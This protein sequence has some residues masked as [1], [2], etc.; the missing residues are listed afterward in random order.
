MLAAL[1]HC[2]RA[3]LW[4]C[5]PSPLCCRPL[6]SAYHHRHKQQ[7]KVVAQ[8]VSDSPHTDSGPCSRHSMTQWGTQQLRCCMQGASGGRPHACTLSHQAI[9]Q[10]H[11]SAKEFD[12][13]CS[14]AVTCSGGSASSASMLVSPPKP[15]SGSTEAVGASSG[16]RASVCICKRCCACLSVNAGQLSTKTITTPVDFVRAVSLIVSSTPAPL[17][18]RGSHASLTAPT[19]MQSYIMC[20]WLHVG[21]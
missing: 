10:P 1:R 2:N 12:I 21:M 17:S 15:C 16:V 14:A 8:A 13:P 20:N 11:Q 7:R 18:E 19:S 4:P 9:K 3:E 6:C 5:S